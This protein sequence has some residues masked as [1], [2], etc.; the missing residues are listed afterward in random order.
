[1]T[2]CQISVENRNYETWT[3]LSKEEPVELAISPFEQKLFHQD[4]FMISKDG[5]IEIAESQ[6]RNK[7]EIPGILVLSTNKSYGRNA[8][9]KL[10]YKCIPNDTH[11]PSFL[12]PY[13]VKQL[14]FSKVAVNLF[15]TFT[16]QEWFQKHPTG[17]IKQTIGLI[18]E[19]NAFYEYQM[20]CKE[21]NYSLKKMNQHILPLIKHGSIVSELCAKFPQ[22]E[23]RTHTHRVFSIDPEGS[24]DFDDAFSIHTEED[25][26][27]Q[28]SIYIANVTLWLEYLN[29]WDFMCVHRVSTVYLPDNKRPMLPGIL[30]D[31]L[32]S[33]REKEER[34]AFVL[35]INYCFRTKSVLSTKITNAVVCLVKNYVYEDPALLKS[36]DYILLETVVREM[37]ANPQMKYMDSLKDSHDIVAYLMIFMNHRCAN[38]LLEKKEGIFRSIVTKVRED[39]DEEKNVELSEKVPENVAKFIKMTSSYSGKYIDLSQ[40]TD[41]Q[42]VSH[43]ILNLDAYIHI[44]SP[45]RRMVDIINMVKIQ[46]NQ[47]IVELSQSARDFCQTWTNK[48]DVLNQQMKQ[49]RIVQ[50]ECQLLHF[51]TNNPDLLNVS[52]KGYTYHKKKRTGVPILSFQYTVYLPEINMMT[53]LFTDEDLPEYSCSQFK[54]FV[55]HNEDKMKRKIRIQKL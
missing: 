3:V 7:K 1:M 55:F 19:M 13:E 51:F 21:V 49:I 12:V 38:M 36:H 29:L 43:R 46:Q 44:T 26:N 40:E 5:K 32:C 28:I 15:V 52:H 53:T 27:V 30:S 23:N 6:T 9:G 54:L 24:L 14:G 41:L 11:L 47:N 18:T 31:N 8:K 34:V 50:N 39:F 17:T 45:I 16:F 35:D 10:L 2:L 4:V 25:G 48:M 20:Y 22:L 33:L 42:N 37:S